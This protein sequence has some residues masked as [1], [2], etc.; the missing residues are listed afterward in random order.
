MPKVLS[1]QVEHVLR[2]DA[3][4]DECVIRHPDNG[5]GMH[6][7][8]KQK[9]GDD[10]ESGLKMNESDGN[11]FLTSAKKS[12]GKAWIR[13]MPGSLTP[14]VNGLVG[15]HT[16]TKTIQYGFPYDCQGIK[17]ARL[18]FVFNQKMAMES[19]FCGNANQSQP[20]AVK[21][22]MDMTKSVNPVSGCSDKTRVGNGNSSLKPSW[23]KP[24]RPPKA[25]TDPSRERHIKGISDIALLR[26]AKL[27]RMKSLRKNKFAKS[28]SDNTSFW[29]LLVTLSFCV[30]MI[31]Q[32]SIYSFALG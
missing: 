20:L 2:V 19:A 24:P 8:P 14:R 7:F 22:D 29:A 25:T 6:L 18:G 10:L 27:E 23:K 31:M 32:G 5:I 17:E 28:S 9:Y 30:I 4:P 1:P 16:G 26:R 21:G 15:E 11:S 12:L 13:F 3:K